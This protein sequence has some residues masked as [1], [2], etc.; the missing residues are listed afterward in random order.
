MSY[1]TKIELVFWG[2]ETGD[3]Q[4]IKEVLDWVAGQS[5]DSL[6]IENLRLALAGN[7]VEFPGYLCHIE[8]KF[9]PMSKNFP[10]VTFGVRGWGE[11]FDDIWLRYFKNGTGTLADPD[12]A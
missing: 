1:Y 10:A 3:E 4:F 8:E 5:W 7:T 9:L 2:Q 12:A 6:D 11:E